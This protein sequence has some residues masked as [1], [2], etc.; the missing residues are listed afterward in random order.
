MD[1]CVRIVVKNEGKDSNKKYI[2]LIQTNF[3]R[4]YVLQ[5]ATETGTMPL[6]SHV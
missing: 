6:S 3:G 1:D 5:A 4:D 2:F